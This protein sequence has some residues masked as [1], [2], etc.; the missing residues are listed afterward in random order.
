MQHARVVEHAQR[1]EERRED[2]LDG[3]PAELAGVLLEV[4]QQSAAL[5]IFVDGVGGVVFSKEVERGVEVREV[6][7]PCERLVELGVFRHERFILGK[8]IGVD[9]D[10]RAARDSGAELFGEIFADKNLAADVLVKRDIS[11]AFAV[12]ALHQT[13]EIAFMKNG[14][15]L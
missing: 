4:A 2:A 10:F 7:E 5:K 1:G 15:G 6:A 3:V 9:I 14:A 11:H 13:D 12:R 8:V